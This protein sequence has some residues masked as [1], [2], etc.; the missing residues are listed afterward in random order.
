[1]NY[2][3]IRTCDIANGEGVRVS[4]FVSGCTHRC[5]GCFSPHTWD[6]GAGTPFTSST[7]Q[8]ILDAVSPSW[9]TGLSLLGGDPMM[10]SNQLGLIGLV[11]RFR[12]EFGDKKTIWCYTG[13]LLEE[14]KD[15]SSPYHTAVT[16]EL[17]ENI[18]VLID[19]PYVE[20]LRNPSLAFRG[21]S[22]QRII[23]LHDTV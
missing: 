19:G 22:N 4:I 12:K 10:P 18:D 3:S 21:S 6:F 9:I 13:C 23:R 1:M 5:K 15:P 20:A 16:D 7:E 11:R 8:D 14:L 2:L 17:L